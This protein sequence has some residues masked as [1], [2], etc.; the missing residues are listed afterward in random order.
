[1]RPYRAVRHSK[2]ILCLLLILL[3]IGAI[4]MISSGDQQKHNY[5]PPEGYVPDQATAAMIAQ[6]VCAP[7]YGADKVKQELPFTATLNQ[8]R[9]VVTGTLPAGHK[10]GVAVVEISKKDG[11]ILRVSHGK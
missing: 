10:G 3:G 11:R 8:D 1:M 5:L 9:W 2:P 4:V 6:A 7:I